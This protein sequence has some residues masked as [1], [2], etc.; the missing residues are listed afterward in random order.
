MENRSLICPACKQENTP[1]SGKCCKCGT[2]IQG[3]GL[4]DEATH[5]QGFKI[6]TELGGF[7]KRR[8]T[9]YE[10]KEP[11]TG[12]GVSYRADFGKVDLYIYDY[13]EKIIPDGIDNEIIK[14]A[15]TNAQAAVKTAEQNKMYKIAATMKGQGFFLPDEKRFPFLLAIYV[16]NY[17]DGAI[18]GSFVHVLGRKN[19]IIKLRASFRGLG[20]EEENQRMMALWKAVADFLT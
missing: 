16:L 10:D 3:E 13:C 5:Y 20:K 1:S 7:T 6:P 4:T 14:L 11:G 17:P 18:D 2:L 8:E 12:I 19:K 15:F 9:I